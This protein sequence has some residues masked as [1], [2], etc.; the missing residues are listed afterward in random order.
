MPTEAIIALQEVPLSE[1]RADL[2][3][4]S[5]RCTSTPRGRGVMQRCRF[6]RQKQRNRLFQR[7]AY[8]EVGKWSIAELTPGAD[9]HEKEVPRRGT[10]VC[11]ASVSN[12]AFNDKSDEE[13]ESTQGLGTLRGGAN[14]TT[15]TSL[16]LL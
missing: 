11:G 13:W 6:Q 7:P 5:P 9:Q 2:Q 1:N 16:N 14:S 12:V 10:T 3:S 4:A 15:G 8:E